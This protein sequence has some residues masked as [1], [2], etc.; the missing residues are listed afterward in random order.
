MLYVVVLDPLPLFR[1]GAVAVLATA[2]CQV[3]SPGDVAGWV[4][5]RRPVIV[6]LT[7]LDEPQWQLL[8]RLRDEP[9]VRAVAVVEDLGA[10]AVRAVHLG[11]GSVLSRAAGPET[12]RRT[13]EAV[14]DGQSVVPAR[15]LAA[16]AGAKQVEPPIL[17]EKHLSWLR[18]LAAGATV[19]ELGDEAGYSERAM[20]RI[21]KQLYQDMG[22]A[23]R[24]QAVLRAQELGWLPRS[25]GRS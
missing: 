6:L 7:L 12:L 8:A 24:M 2:G 11:A 19:A 20:F 3:E 22:V 25:L 13:V 16:L 5:S 15:V 4:V 23:N 14:A 17:A 1:Q 9:G 10:A 21:L 18:K